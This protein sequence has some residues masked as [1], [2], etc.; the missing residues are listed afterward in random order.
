MGTL[1]RLAL[2]AFLLLF[3]LAANAAQRNVIL[4]IG[5]G[6]G[7]EHLKAASLYLTGGEEGL[8]FQRY[9]HRGR[10]RTGSA[11]S[12]VT[13]SAA[14]ATALATGRKVNNGVLSKA[15]PGDGSNL[16]TILEEYQKLGYATGLVTTTSV[17]HATPAAFAAHA[18]S[19]RDYDSILGEIYFSVKPEVLLGGG[20]KTALTPPP[21]YT[22]VTDA[23]GLLSIVP[24]RVAKLEGRFG[25][26]FMPYESDG[27]G[28]F[29]HLSQM[30]GA[31]LGVLEKNG[32]GLFLMVECGRID[33]AA[34]ANDL[35]RTIGETIECSKAVSVAETWS[36]KRKATL[37]VVT[38]DHETGGLE[39]M[40]G[41]PKGR[42]PAVSW[43]TSAHTA[44]DVP[45][46]A[47]GVGS[48]LVESVM[49]NTQI[50][51]L[52]LPAN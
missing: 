12:P 50:H 22:R 14:A 29:P 24:A 45:I 17:E 6:M 9:E 38:A 30:T 42:L 27:V 37:I 3:S 35:L 10:V 4:F 32:K 33:H 43:K 18:A 2:L 26:D 52:L 39:V 16:L 11:D 1:R 19:R 5:D 21:E 20:R 49:E 8:S 7:F 13:D 40:K 23:K 36:K 34:Q 51:Y 44:A 15:L 25:E 46:Y 48:E 31:A 28:T 47:T 41:A